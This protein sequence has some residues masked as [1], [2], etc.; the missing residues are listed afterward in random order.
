M[1]MTST[2]PAKISGN[3]CQQIAAQCTQCGICAVNCRFLTEYGTPGQ[4]A[5]N[6]DADPA[7]CQ[8]LAFECSLCGLCT[9]VCPKDLDPRAMFLDLRREAVDAGRAELKKYK[10]LLNYERKGC[11]KLFS[12]YNLPDQCDTIFFPG[13]TLPGTR[14]GHTLKAFE[15][16]KARIPRLGIVL[17]C[18]TKPSHD[19]GR[20]DFF[21]GMFSEMADFLEE[22]GITT[23]VVAC[24]NCHTIFV[25]HGQRFEVKTIYQIMADDPDPDFTLP[26]DTNLD[27]V[28][29]HDPCPVRNEPQV[30]TAVRSL[31]QRMG[32][33]IQESK[34]TGKR[35]IC[36]GEGGAVACVN[37]EF[38]R[39]WSAKRKQE[40]DGQRILTYCA[41]CVN[42][43][44]RTSGAFHVLDLVF[45]P[46]RTLAGRPRVAK[47]PF[48]Y[49]NRLILKR[50]V[51]AM[52]GSVHRERTF[53]HGN[54]PNNTH[55]LKR[56]MIMAIII[57]AMAGFRAAGFTDNL[58]PE[59]LRQ[60]INSFGSL[61][62]VIYLLIYTLAPCLLLPGLPLTILGGILFGPVWGVV[63]SITGATAGA[64][65]AFLI[66]RY[67]SAGFIESQL[68]HP[69]WQKLYS[70]VE[71]NGWK[72]VAFTRL[73]PLFPFN[74]LNYAL[75]L[76]PIKFTHYILTTLVCMLPACI[77]LVVFSS[78]ILD[79]F[80]GK[81]STELILGI[82]LMV[83]VFTG[84]AV[85]RRI[86]PG[87]N[88]PGQNSR[89]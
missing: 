39:T 51:R 81:S 87:Q 60:T 13:C 78:S 58:H 79:L 29:V 77:A 53:V 76:T 11:S 24:P 62:P 72:V 48:T 27:P 42:F 54:E 5:L 20:D 57:A 71:K 18:C 88:F 65:L 74:L 41:G 28:T 45:D 40:A 31:V 26:P 50:N 38:A 66:S 17:D 15:Y 12:Y 73:I 37:P 25:T 55:R 56:I 10:R 44:S 43:L 16:L 47:A 52:P 75:G 80:N 7:T 82:V 84:P 61:G 22:N 4:L 23:I 49:L 9:A 33:S 89:P 64:G 85:Y 19:L 32:I 69:K 67:V 46:E 8:D 70:G 36:C 83:L 68:S 86:K 63:Y 1:L 21:N 59:H 2:Q 35:T 34:H 6:H 14:P 30:Q 3:T